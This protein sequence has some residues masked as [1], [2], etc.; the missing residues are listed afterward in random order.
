LVAIEVVRRRSSHF[1]G[2]NTNKGK[3]KQSKA[4]HFVDE[5]TK[6]GKRQNTNKNTNNVSVGDTCHGV[7]ESCIG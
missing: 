1:V 2:E 6:I 3:D 5:N 4:S 7:V